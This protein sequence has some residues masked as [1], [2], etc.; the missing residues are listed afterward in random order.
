[1][2]SIQESQDK[3]YNFKLEAYIMSLVV[4]VFNFILDTGLLVFQS[5]FLIFICDKL[6]GLKI[7]KGH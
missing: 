3:K 6:N 4:K 1:M 5:I 7:K 2:E